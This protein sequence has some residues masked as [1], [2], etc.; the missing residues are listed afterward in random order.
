MVPLDGKTNGGVRAFP[1]ARSSYSP[2]DT[3]IRV[4]PAGWRALLIAEIED[5]HH[6]TGIRDTHGNLVP[7]KCV[8]VVCEREPAEA[9]EEAEAQRQRLES[10]AA[11]D[12][13]AARESFAKAAAAEQEAEK[14]KKDAD[15]ARGERDRLHPQVDEHRRAKTKLEDD[16]AK[17]RKAFGEKAWKEA[18]GA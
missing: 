10:D 11:R 14:H 15:V 8:V 12:R 16:M 5:P 2:H 1:I 4:A 17:A 3:P 6:M 7:S 18:L 13:E 9:A